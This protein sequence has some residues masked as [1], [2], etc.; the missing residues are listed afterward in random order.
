MKYFDLPVFTINKLEKLNIA[1]NSLPLKLAFYYS[2]DFHRKVFHVPLNASTPTAT[3]NKQHVLHKLCVRIALP[4][5]NA[6][7]AIKSKAAIV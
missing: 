6:T 2:C 7:F 5:L 4:T 3:L 1:Y